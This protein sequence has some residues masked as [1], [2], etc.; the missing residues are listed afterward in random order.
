MVRFTAY[1]S[2]AL[3]LTLCFTFDC[4]ARSMRTVA[5]TGR[6]ADSAGGDPLTFTQI[7][8]ATINRY[9]QVALVATAQA[10]GQP[11]VGGVWSEGGYGGLRL[12]ALDG[13]AA[14]GV[15]G[16]IFNSLSGNYPIINNVGQTLFRGGLNTAPGITSK[17]DSG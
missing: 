11:V 15:S 17:N 8:T 3:L 2:L 6:S 9:S 10:S 13:R 14:P 4:S 1:T 5:L 16:G 12:V 7:G